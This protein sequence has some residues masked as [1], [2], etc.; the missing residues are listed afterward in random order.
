MTT[1]TRPTNEQLRTAVL[2]ELHWLPSVDSARISVS[3]DGGCVTLSGTVP[4]YPETMAAAKAVL[5][6]RGITA[7][8]QELSVRGPW[9]APTDSE[10]GRQAAEAVERAVN[11]P[12]TVKVSVHEHTITLSGEV[13]WQYQRE[14]ACRAVN[15]INGVTSVVNKMDVRPGVVAIGI[16]Q[17]ITAALVR[18]AQFEGEHLTVTTDTRG[19]VTM[20]GT[21]RSAAEKRQAETVCWRAPGVISVLNQLQI[22]G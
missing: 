8:A 1:T 13:T 20:T 19:V 4:T 2:D 7:V 10:I 5:A 11:V 14:A 9:A 12:G 17:D 15:Y 22:A 16:A 3:V 21:V 18:N 6:V